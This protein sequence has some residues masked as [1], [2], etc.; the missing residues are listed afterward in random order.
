LKATN[1]ARTIVDDT[2]HQEANKRIKKK[3]KQIKRE[4]QREQNT[5]NQHVQETQ[6]LL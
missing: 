4:K 3:E 5:N 1:K 6:K 2:K